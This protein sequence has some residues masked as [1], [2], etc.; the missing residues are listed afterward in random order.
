MVGPQGLASKCKKYRIQS[1]WV[2][3]KQADW[4]STYV[5][6]MLS[7]LT[8]FFLDVL[9][10]TV[11]L[12]DSEKWILPNVGMSFNILQNFFYCSTK[13]WSVFIVIPPL[14]TVLYI[15]LQHC[16]FL[17]PLFSALTFSTSDKK[18]YI[19]ES[20]SVQVVERL[21]SLPM[22]YWSHFVR[23]ENL[24]PTTD[25]L[26]IEN[27]NCYSTPERGTVCMCTC[28]SLAQT[29][30]HTQLFGGWHLFLIFAANMLGPLTTPEHQLNK[31]PSSSSLSQRMKS[32][33]TPRYNHTE[34]NTQ[35]NTMF[36]PVQWS[37]CCYNRMIKWHLKWLFCTADSKDQIFN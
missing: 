35:T 24:Q 3:D 22:D 10:I 18:I 19:F 30:V 16:K 6:I 33:L 5:R 9:C 28:V 13:N 29:S 31:T 14:Y 36:D 15:F 21:L 17:Q 37:L 23:V 25:Q 32:T 26:I 8:Q 2:C 20:H 34:K 7:S 11:S 4:I 12:W 1:I 27:A